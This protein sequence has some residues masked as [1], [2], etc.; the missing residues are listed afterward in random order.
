MGKQRLP[1]I[2]IT[3]FQPRPHIESAQCSSDPGAFFLLQTLAFLQG[4][5]TP[6]FACIEGP[7]CA[8]SQRGC[9]EWA[10]RC[11]EMRRYATGCLGRGVLRRSL[12]G[13]LGFVRSLSEEGEARLMRALLSSCG[14]VPACWFQEG[15]EMGGQDARYIEGGLPAWCWREVFGRTVVRSGCRRREVWW[16]DALGDVPDLGH[17][18]DHGFVGVT[19]SPRGDILLFQL[20][21][22]VA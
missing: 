22:K 14:S 10:A 4:G 11:G 3:P 2:T 21:W 9:I 5:G 15:E 7:G 1:L 13:H 12:V 19:S 16:D 18:A 20:D 17:L 8:I 6:C